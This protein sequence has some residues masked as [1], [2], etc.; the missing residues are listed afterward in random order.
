[1]SGDN[2]HDADE[3]ELCVLGLGRAELVEQLVEP[4]LWCAPLQ[5]GVQCC[6]GS[7][8]NAAAWFFALALVWY[9]RDSPTSF[10]F[11]RWY[12]PFR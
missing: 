12:A 11:S 10:G 5:R 4:R 9:T 2:L 6:R 7:R 8:C 3:Q 1:V